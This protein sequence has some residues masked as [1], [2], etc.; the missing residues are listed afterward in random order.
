MFKRLLN[1]FACKKQEHPFIITCDDIQIKLTDERSSESHAAAWSSIDRITV[2]TTGEGPWREDA[3]FVFECKSDKPF[4]VP[5]EARGVGELITKLTS[6]DG[7]D[8][9]LF[10]VA[11]GCT[12]NQRFICWEK[13]ITT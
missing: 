11:M 13:P 6:L 2:Y 3:Y 1:F 10:M 9:Q 7:F 8:I 5:S 4:I 12:N